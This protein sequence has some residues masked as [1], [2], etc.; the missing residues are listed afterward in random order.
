MHKV[1]RLALL[2]D[3]PPAVEDAPSMRATGEALRD[4]STA[5]CAA[6]DKASYLKTL[7]HYCQSYKAITQTTLHQCLKLEG[8]HKYCQ[9]VIVTTAYV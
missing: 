6:L 1:D 7:N 9:K 8:V 3:I 2:L 5:P 4:A